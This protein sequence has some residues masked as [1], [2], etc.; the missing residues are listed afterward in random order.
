MEAAMRVLPLLIVLA[1]CGGPQ[2]APPTPKGFVE[3]PDKYP[4]HY[5]AVTADGL[6]IAAR[7]IEHDP[8]GELG[9]WSE[10]VTNQLRRAGYALLD[11]R[12]VTTTAGL[13]GT[14]LRF[15]HDEGQRPHLYYVTLFVT[16]ATIYLLE[17][18]GTREQV[19]QRAADI[20]WA[21]ANFK[22]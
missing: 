1:A 6:V 12:E 9:F 3:I 18:G 4:Y 17:A 22:P 15:G 11:Q 5:R 7:A 21:V 14:Q 2:L 20:D 16:D 19:E 8:R 10:A 13:A